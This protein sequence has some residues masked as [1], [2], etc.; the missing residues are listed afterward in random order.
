MTPQ[1]TPRVKPWAAL[2]AG[3]IALA[4]LVYGLDATPLPDR[5]SPR[6]FKDPSLRAVFDGWSEIAGSVGLEISS[7][8]LRKRAWAESKR[9]IQGRRALL[10]PAAPVFAWSGTGQAWGLFAFPE[11]NPARLY[12]EGSDGEVWTRLHQTGDRARTLLTPQLQSRQLRAFYQNAAARS[13]PTPAYR[14]F[15][16]WASRRAF[17]EH[18]ELVSVRVGFERLSALPSEV[19]PAPPGEPFHVVTRRRPADAPGEAAP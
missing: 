14:R 7:R 16:T 4:V 6:S 19:P 10:A 15:V 8:D 1:S 13:E 11:T 3:L 18:P 2:R 9:V 12:I 17:D 5:I